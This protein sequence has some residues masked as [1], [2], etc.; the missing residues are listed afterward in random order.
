MSARWGKGVFVGYDR[1]SNTYSV[2]DGENVIHARSLARLPSDERWD[3]ETKGKVRA[4]P[5][6][7][8]AKDIDAELGEPCDQENQPPVVEPKVPKAFRIVYN[9]LRVHGFTKGCKQCDH[10]ANG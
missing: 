5:W 9:D 8:K 2:A 3:S 10:N 1:A 6:M 4:T 7:T